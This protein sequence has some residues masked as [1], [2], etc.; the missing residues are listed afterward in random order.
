MRAEVAPEHQSVPPDWVPVE[1][2][3][4]GMDRTTL[5]PAAIVVLLVALAVWGLPAL[6]RAVP[7]DDPARAGDVIRV[8]QVEFDPAAGWSIDS[9]VLA[10]DPPESGGFPNTA[11]VSKDGFT[12][13]VVSDTFDGTPAELMAQLQK[14]NERLSD[15]VTIDMGQVETFHTSQ[16]ARGVAGRF[17]FA[18]GAGLVAAYVF[19]GTGVEVVA[20]G[21]DQTDDDQ[22]EADIIR[23]IRSIRPVTSVE[24]S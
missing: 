4:L 15:G 7:V 19:D 5:L 21:P 2:R 1:R 16:G 12:F 13:S 24:A 3:W 9:G 22:I 10:S 14:N 23:M 11:Q 18:S 8:D 20:S 17:T 6:D